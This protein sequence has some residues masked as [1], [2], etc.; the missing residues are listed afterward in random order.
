MARLWK[1]EVAG[2]ALFAV[3]LVVFASGGILRW[4]G[5]PGVWP[6][7]FLVGGAVLGLPLAVF[8]LITFRIN[9]FVQSGK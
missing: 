4:Y 5:V 9:A 3:A 2:I 8:L 7:V 6:A 1:T